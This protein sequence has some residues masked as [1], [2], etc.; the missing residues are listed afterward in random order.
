M[1][2][3]EKL[4]EIIENNYHV[5]GNPA[6]DGGLDLEE[7]GLGWGGGGVNDQTEDVV[8]IDGEGANEDDDAIDYIHSDDAVASKMAVDEQ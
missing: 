5:P 7:I 8:V 3:I 4:K 6:P 1:P 2:F